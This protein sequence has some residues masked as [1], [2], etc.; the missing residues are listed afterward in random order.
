MSDKA[1][2]L[3]KQAI[4][5][6]LNDDGASETGAYRDVVTEV[7]KFAKKKFPNLSNEGLLHSICDEGYDGFMEEIELEELKK[8]YHW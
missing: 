3:I 5:S 2:R 6:H 1:R 7:L 4:Q 8:L